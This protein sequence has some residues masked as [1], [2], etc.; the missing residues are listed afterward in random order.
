MLI[1]QIIVKEDE[2]YLG[3]KSE[4]LD[5]SAGYYRNSLLLYVLFLPISNLTS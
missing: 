1:V 3:K 5:V 4:L 2:E